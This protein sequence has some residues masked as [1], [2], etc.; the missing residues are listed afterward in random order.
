MEYKLIMESW[1]KHLKESSRRGGRI[2]IDFDGLMGSNLIKKLPSELKTGYKRGFPQIK[3]AN[4]GSGSGSGQTV[5]QY[6]STKNI[7]TFNKIYWSSILKR[8]NRTYSNLFSY[9]K[10]LNKYV[11]SDKITWIFRDWASY[12][13]VDILIH[14]LTHAKQTDRDGPNRVSRN[15]DDDQF[16]MQGNNEWELEAIQTQEKHRTFINQKLKGTLSYLKKYVF[17]KYI[18][19]TGNDPVESYLK[20]AILGPFTQGKSKIG[21]SNAAGGMGGMRSGQ[22]TELESYK[23]MNKLAQAWKLVL[24]TRRRVNKGAPSDEE[25]RNFLVNIAEQPWHLGREPMN[26]DRARRILRQ[27][28]LRTPP[29]R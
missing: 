5:A 26:P 14:E 23:Y 20:G 10:D 28:G 4:L 12:L 7:I 6:S 16:L 3:L 29:K 22:K 19:A 27:K 18:K 8:L 13:L 17:K 2:R 21:P 25:F 11:D 24:R 15:Y 1:R 9:Y